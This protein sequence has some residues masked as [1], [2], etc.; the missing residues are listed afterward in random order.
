VQHLLSRTGHGEHVFTAHAEL[1]GGKLIAMFD[2]LLAG[3][4]SQGYELV[5]LEAIHRALDVTRLPRCEVLQGTV[6]GRSGA[7][8]VQGEAA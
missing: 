4:K 5:A 7:L 1:E 6:P 3:W 2:A 8:A